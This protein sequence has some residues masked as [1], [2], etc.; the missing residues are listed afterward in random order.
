MALT[1]IAEDGTGLADANSLVTVTY[2]NDYFDLRGNST[3]AG[4]SDEHKKKYLVLATDYV[5]F[6]FAQMFIST[7]LYPDVQ[8]LSFPR[9]LSV[10]FPDAI[11]KA[12]CE[13]AI[14]SYSGNLTSEPVLHNGNQIVRKRERMIT[15]EEEVHYSAGKGGKFL[16]HPIPDALLAPY[17]KAGGRVIR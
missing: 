10:S 14:L 8:A 5:E 1:F 16:P 2:A 4:L 6:R 9:D 3:W 15:L 17:L 13:Y 12:I 11:K 7:K